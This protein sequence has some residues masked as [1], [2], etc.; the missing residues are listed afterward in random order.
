MDNCD[1]NILFLVLNICTKCN[2]YKITMDNY[3][4]I[5]LFLVLNICTASHVNMSIFLF[6]STQTTK[7][8]FSSKK[9]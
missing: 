5:I 8:Y 6:C 2:F 3:D 4:S 7:H 9:N 1:S